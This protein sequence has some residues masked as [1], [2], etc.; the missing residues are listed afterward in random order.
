MEERQRTPPW[1]LWEDAADL[2]PARWCDDTSVLCA[3][4]R[5]SRVREPR[6]DWPRERAEATTKNHTSVVMIGGGTELKEEKSGRIQPVPKHAC[7]RRPDAYIMPLG[8][9]FYY[10]SALTVVRGLVSN[11]R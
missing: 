8:T 9:H 3:T 7:G 5:P 6:N 1:L 10:L 4:R 11:Y 2:L